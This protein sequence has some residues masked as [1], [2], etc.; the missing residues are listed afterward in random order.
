MRA[1]TFRPPVSFW[2]ELN[3]CLPP[4]TATE[5]E[6]RLQRDG[7]LA[8]TAEGSESSSR[9]QG[10]GG[11]DSCFFSFPTSYFSFW[12]VF[13]EILIWGGLCFW[14]T[15]FRFLGLRRPPETF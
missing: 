1:P 12:V 7:S 9:R 5:E 15:P 8:G 2:P 10:K 3:A 11:G 4:S 13:Y 6:S 14:R